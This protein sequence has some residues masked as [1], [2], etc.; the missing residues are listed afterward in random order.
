MAKQAPQTQVQ[1]SE[2][3][4]RAILDAAIK[5]IASDGYRR[6]T[7]D[8]IGQETGMSRGLVGYH[9]R[10]KVR[11][12]EAVVTDIR[13]RMAADLAAAG[14]GSTDGLQSIITQ[15]DMYMDRLQHRPTRA[16]VMLTLATESVAEERELQRAI[17]DQLASVRANFRQWIVEGHADGSVRRDVDPD[18][19]AALLHAIQR[20]VAVQ[21][22]VDPDAFDVAP[23]RAAAMDFVRHAIA[24]RPDAV[25]DAPAGRGT[26]QVAAGKT[27][28]SR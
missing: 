2:A 26:K 4:R 12:M 25:Q 20:G 13:E 10:S 1:R 15:L 27:A 24:A 19:Y 28:A 18:G 17:R 7:F 21:A 16:Y 6:V 5:I 11:L 23:A 9:F 14:L 8:R 3:S 22:L